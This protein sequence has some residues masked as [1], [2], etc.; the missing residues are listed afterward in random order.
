MLASPSVA[1]T[2][3]SYEGQP[4]TL[5]PVPALAWKTLATVTITRNPP[6]APN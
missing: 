4:G 5:H 1:A 3:A 2:L 6:S